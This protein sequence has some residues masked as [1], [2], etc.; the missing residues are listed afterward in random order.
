MLAGLS[1]TRRVLRQLLGQVWAS[2]NLMITGRVARGLI[3]F[4]QQVFHLWLYRLVLN[5]P[6]ALFEALS[7][8]LG[9]G[10]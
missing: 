7:N 9:V 10:R 5:T 6:K 1:R 3:K 8:D 2:V 4:P